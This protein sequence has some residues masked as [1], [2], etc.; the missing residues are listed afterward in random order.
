[1][2]NSDLDKKFQIA[3]LADSVPQAISA[4]PLAFASYAE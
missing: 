1:M 2:L 3:H 4:V